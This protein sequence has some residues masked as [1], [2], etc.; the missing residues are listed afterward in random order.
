MTD[1]YLEA[2]IIIAD[3]VWIG[4]GSIITSGVKIGEGAVVGA[5]S[6]IT[7]DVEE[8]AIPVGP[9]HLE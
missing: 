1:S 5:G 7:K 2:D 8:N 3:N 9:T 4:A 6:I